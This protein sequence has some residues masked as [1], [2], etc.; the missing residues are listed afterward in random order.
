MI[1]LESAINADIHDNFG[2]FRATR[3]YYPLR[4]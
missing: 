2:L 3:V 4:P 1:A